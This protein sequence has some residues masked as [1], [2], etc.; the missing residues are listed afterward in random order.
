M[1]GEPAV[2]W[3]DKTAIDD[4]VWVVRRGERTVRALRVDFHGTVATDFKAGGFLDLQPAGPRGV[5]RA[6]SV[7]AF[8]EVEI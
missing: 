2:V 8:D 6:D 7:T 1:N 3:Y 4:R 5:I